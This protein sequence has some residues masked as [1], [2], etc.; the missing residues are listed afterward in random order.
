MHEIQNF[1]KL[2]RGRQKKREAQAFQVEGD[3][4]LVARFRNFTS[5]TLHYF[6]LGFIDEVTLAKRDGQGTY[7]LYNRLVIPNFFNG[8]QHM[9]SFRS[10]RASDVPKW[11]HQ[12]ANIET[13]Q[14][15]Y[16]YDIA[17]YNQSI[18]VTEGIFDVWAYHEIGVTAV[19]TYGAHLADEQYKLL[20]KTGADIILSYDN[21]DAGNKARDKAIEM[22]KNKTNLFL[23]TLPKG[24]DPE[25]I[26]RQELRECYEART[27]WRKS[28][29]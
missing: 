23:V 2:M 22:L 14:Y 21:D 5:D 4:K 17:R 18:V 13:G 15:L 16:N 27:S 9:L 19:C 3:I 11:S 8:V 12:P 6:G 28:N 20:L 26:T 24:K 7:K 29:S 10:T 1:I 25:N